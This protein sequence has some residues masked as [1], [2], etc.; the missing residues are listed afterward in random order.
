MTYLGEFAA[1]ATSVLFSVTSTQFTL[2]GREV[3]SVVVN[4]TRLVF[5]VI[6]VVT[7]HLIAGVALPFPISPGLNPF[8]G[9]LQLPQEQDSFVQPH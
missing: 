2:A 8:W 4:R 5:A 9:H 3:G 6:L 7:A 1:L